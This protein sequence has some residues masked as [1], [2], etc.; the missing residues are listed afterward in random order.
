MLV[1]V[2]VVTD[3]DGVSGGSRRLASRSGA[4]RT[5]LLP[6]LPHT[7]DR[8]VKN[9]S[10][11]AVLPALSDDV[12]YIYIYIY[13]RLRRRMYDG[14]RRSRSTMTTH[15]VAYFVRF[16]FG[17]SFVCRSRIS[18]ALIAILSI[19][20]PATSELSPVCRCLFNGVL[21]FLSFSPASGAGRCLNE[22]RT[23]TRADPV[24]R[25]RRS[26]GSLS[27]CHAKINKMATSVTER[28]R[29]RSLPNGFNRVRTDIYI[30]EHTRYSIST[31]K[32]DSHRWSTRCYRTA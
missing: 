21:F 13:T 32:L 22:A 6:P 1:V 16:P 4:S 10:R 30:R 9:G 5:D 19:D 12:I 18:I 25:D 23:N 7:H 2:V 28:L 15:S 31:G 14:R 17:C 3:G 29:L 8:S 26:R 27:L 11:Y 24:R 20:S